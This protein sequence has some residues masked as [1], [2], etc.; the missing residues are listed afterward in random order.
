MGWSGALDVQGGL[1]IHAA[2]PKL[3]H[4]I[5][6]M[7]G[8]Q[9]LWHDLPGHQPD[10]VVRVLFQGRRSHQSGVRRRR[11][12]GF[13]WRHYHLLPLSLLRA[14]RRRRGGQ[15]TLVHVQVLRGKGAVLCHGFDVAEAG[16]RRT[17][18]LVRAGEAG[19]P[20]LLCSKVETI[21]RWAELWDLSGSVPGRRANMGG[22][23]VLG[24]AVLRAGLVRTQGRVLWRTDH[25]VSRAAP[26]GQ[27]ASHPIILWAGALF[28][29]HWLTFGE[30]AETN[31]V[32]LYRGAF[33]FGCWRA[34][35]LDFLVYL[36]DCEYW[37]RTCSSGVEGALVAWL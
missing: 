3:L 25:K 28:V 4:L 15:G 23:R 26:L 37:R 19:E 2:W 10:G 5:P 35:M 30:S 13:P 8:L 12:W 33:P 7:P 14:A 1:L 32:E 17:G 16:L 20:F 24:A 6:L 21:R 9:L 27:P 31:H 11:L 22:G 18:V 36:K 34:N 29:G